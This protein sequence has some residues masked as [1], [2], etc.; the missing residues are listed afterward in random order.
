MK[1][2]TYIILLLLFLILGFNG[3]SAQS[4][5]E[6]EPAP[7]NIFGAEY[8]R[9]LPDNRVS[10]Q[11]EA[12]E[13][14]SLQ[15]E[16]PPGTTYDMQKGANG[17]WTV[18][19]DPQ[20]PG[21]HYYSLTIDGV[22]VADPASKSFYGMGRWASGIDIPE[23]GVDFYQVK[24]VAHGDVRMER[25]FSSTTDS[26]RR[27]FVYT[28]PGYDANADER[29]PVLYLQHGGG[30]DET[31]W[32]RQ[33]KTDIILD[34]LIA[35]GQAEPMLVVIANGN[36]PSIMGSGGYN[37]E[38]MAIFADE[39]FNNVIP[40][41]ESRYQV[42][43]DRED[44]ALA[45]LSMGGGQTFYTALRYTDRFASA[46]IF[47]TGLFGGIGDPFDAEEI[48][49]GLLSDSESFNDELDV[50]YI[51][52]GEQDRRI[53]FTKE[54]VANFRENGLDVQF[55]SFPGGHEWQVWRKS[56]HDFAQKIFK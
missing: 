2:L 19:T 29:Y 31:G 40:T 12:P 32:V 35:E 6:G 7:T 1:K 20:M 21:F 5:N 27:F 37:D 51:S 50:L 39:L 18:T 3:V 15:I 10:F 23:E 14:R 26:W 38:S 33:G 54:T 16:V 13:A 55:S 45:G 53:E 46:G 43:T 47:S 41:V 30:E 56:L 4:M 24:D 52:V 36:A 17:T 8:P 28:P 49:P 9:I 25:Y 48:I 34:N 22:T 42:S 44:R 11:V